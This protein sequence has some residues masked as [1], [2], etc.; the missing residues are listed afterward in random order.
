MVAKYK[1]IM[2]GLINEGNEWNKRRKRTG[3]VEEKRGVVVRESE[4]VSFGVGSELVL[5]GKIYSVLP[6]SILPLRTGFLKKPIKMGD[7]YYY[8]EVKG[9]GREGREIYF[10]EHVSGDIFYGMYLDWALRDFDRMQFARSLNLP[11]TVPIAVLEIPREEYIK[12]GLAGFQETL[13]AYLSFSGRV[14]PEKTEEIIGEINA[15]DPK[16]IAKR[17]VKNTK[18]CYPDD[19]VE[20][21]RILVSKLI[22]PEKRGWGIENAANALL[23]GRRVG[24]FIKA[25]RCPV[26]VGD[27][28]SKNID[29]PEFR[30]IA[31]SMGRTFRIL[32]EN[33][34]LHHCPGT[35]NWTIAGELT[36]FADT[37]D[38]NTE[39]EQLKEHIEGLVKDDRIKNGEMKSFI[40]YL[41][42]PPHT[43]LL[44]SY[45]L[46][47][48]FGK[49][50]TVET[51][52]NKL[53][54]ILKRHFSASL[55][56]Q[57]RET[58]YYVSWTL[59][60]WAGWLGYSKFFV[61]LHFVLS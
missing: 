56:L 40:E 36:D 55:L 26:R 17:L 4:L 54:R 15:W 43:G 12:K 50:T 42:G 1:T 30:E 29:K 19:L 46:E 27:P 52:T 2:Q 7:E 61:N 48:M 47:G 28:S 37:F 11:V 22:N 57:K 3:W 51:A 58:K 38:L 45:F 60:G 14:E 39:E 59:L 9:Y 25:S 6:R 53:L 23:S 20:G 49:G 16:D 34:I 10:Q 35:G 44:C 5:R 33:G 8:W 24:Y 41:I 21:I 31:K 32:L 13:K 18:L